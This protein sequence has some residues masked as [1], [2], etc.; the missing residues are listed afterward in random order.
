MMIQKWL[1]WM[2]LRWLLNNE[3][4]SSSME[5]K[6]NVMKMVTKFWI[7]HLLIVMQLLHK[8]GNICC[9][10]SNYQYLPHINK[11]KFMCQKYKNLKLFTKF[12]DINIKECIQSYM[13][14]SHSSVLQMQN[15]HAV[16]STSWVW[17]FTCTHNISG[18]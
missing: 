10:K 12:L 7:T 3:I 13:N 18:L 11:T 14:K 6:G 5:I 16:L 4:N 8:L 2:V 9:K 15:S 17:Y 1:K